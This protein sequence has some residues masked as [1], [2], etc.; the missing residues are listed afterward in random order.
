M[1]G[2][3]FSGAVELLK[4]ART[5][6]LC[7]HRNPD[8]DCL[9]SVLALAQALQSLGIQAT[10]LLATREKPQ[11]YDFLPGFGQL[12]PAA[13][14]SGQPDVFV[15]LDVPE[16]ARMDDAAA[17]RARSAVTVKIDHHAGPADIAD[18]SYIDE[19]AA[20]VGVLVWELLP[21]LGVEPTPGMARCC[22]AALLTDT[23]S[24]RFQNADQRA[25]EAAAQMVAAGAEPALVATMVYQRK[26]LAALQLESRVA[27]RAQF[28]C[29]G[30]LVISWM[31]DADLVELG[32]SKDDCEELTDVVRQIDGPEV[33]VILRGQGD[34]IRGSIRSKTSHDVQAI[35]KKMNGGGHRAASGFTLYGNIQEAIQTVIAHVAASFELAGEEAVR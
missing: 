8:G 18:Y 7:G 21:Q 28:A 22:Y 14:Y 6:A 17:V 34:H 2:F 16:D 35:A 1:A 12:V 32:A 15:M 19:D 10:P 30:R 29:D 27:Q 9:G 11:L 24:F 33:S 25:F 4:N 3:D 31:D 26:S 23:G 13:D 5:V 20:A